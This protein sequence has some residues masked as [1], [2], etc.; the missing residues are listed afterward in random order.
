AAR[1]QDQVEAINKELTGLGVA[2]DLQS[3]FNFI[4]KWLLLGPFDNT[5][6]LGFDKAYPTEQSVDVQ[7][8]YEGKNGEIRWT[9]CVTTDPYGIVD[10]NQAL[11]KNM[12]AVG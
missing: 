9:E 6:G 5:Q 10:L 7:A 1:D 12:G 2:V 3:R 8:D 11:G 4:S